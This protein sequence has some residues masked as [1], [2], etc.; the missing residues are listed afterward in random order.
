MRP[1]PRLKRKLLS[2]ASLVVLLGVTGALLGEE[3]SDGWTVSP[4]AGR[5][6]GA[7]SAKPT[8]RVL[9]SRSS[10]GAQIVGQAQVGRTLVAAVGGPKPK[11]PRRLRFQWVVCD[12][13]GLSCTDLAGATRQR[14]IVSSSEIGVRLRVR[15]SILGPTRPRTLLSRVTTRVLSSSDPVIAAAGDIACD[16]TSTRFNNGLGT[17]ANCRQKWTSDLLLASGLS[18]V[19]PL[20]DLQYECGAA[21]GFTASYAP[22]WG[23]V[24]AITYPAVGN[25]EYG[26][27]CQSNDASAYFAYFGPQ[28]GPTPGGW[29]SYDIGTWHLIA[30]NS[31]CGYGSGTAKVGGCGP[32]SPQETWL[33]QDLA[34]HSSLCTLAY[35]HEPRFSSGEHGDAQAMATIWND[36]VAAH[37][38]V[39]LSGHNHDYERFDPIGTT[40]P[41]PPVSGAALSYQD[42]VLDPNGIRE[43]VVG[44]GGKNHYGFG[45]QPPLA[46]EVVRDPTTYGILKLT[47]HPSGYDWQFVNDPG[48]GTFTDSGSGACH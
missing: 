30:L 1:A 24:K 20:G 23:R 7:T 36:L 8:S 37:V 35:W 41:Q 25:H 47:L 46:G 5:H 15:I 3:A 32:G 9:A 38:D 27:S 4:A 31:E 48:S 2:L 33:Q 21:T 11:K 22:S 10:A 6:V 19:L 43:F 18:A 29:Y 14:H 44:T 34:A 17:K 13:T 28:A 26:K 42:P 40:P 45:S 12:W 39:V 16:P